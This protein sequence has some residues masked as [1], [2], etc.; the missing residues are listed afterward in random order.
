MAMSDAQKMAFVH[1]MTH[2]ALSHVQ[3]FDAGGVAETEDAVKPQIYNPFDPS[4]SGSVPIGS[5]LT[6]EPGKSQILSPTSANSTTQPGLVT[7]TDNTTAG[8]LFGKTADPSGGFGHAAAGAINNVGGIFQG[9][10]SAFT[11]QNNY[12]AGTAPTTQLNYE[13]PAAQGVS[14]LQA[15]YGQ[16]NALLNNQQVLENQLAAQAAGAGPNPAQAAL[17]QN[18]GR[19]IKQAAALAASTRGAGANAGMVAENAARQGAETQQNAIG[20]A[21]TL[22]AQQRLDAQKAQQEQQQ[23]ELANIQGEQGIQGSLYGASA[24][25]NNAQNNTNVSNYG[26][27]QGINAQAAQNNAN[28]V[29]KTTSGFVSGAGSALAALFAQGGEV[30][31]PSH[32]KKIH[33][34]YYARGGE[35]NFGVWNPGSPS[36]NVPRLPEGVGVDIPNPSSM[37]KGMKGGS[38]SSSSTSG[39]LP[40]ASGDYDPLGGVTTTG[41]ENADPLAGITST[42]FSSAP[43]YSKGGKVGDRLKSGGKVP[44]KPK[45]SHDAYKNDTVSAKLSPGEVVIDLNTLKDKGKLGQMARFVAQNIERKKAGRA[46]V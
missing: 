24:N 35:V 3:H 16:S 17:N 44:G 22:E 8:G 41:S 36:V 38:S 30:E 11:N 5:N 12:Q 45:V 46:L 26:M 1:K 39:G 13:V 29:N 21:A 15:G 9:L 40:A 14:N 23:A 28:A 31:L 7:T 6:A 37:M 43:D 27:A 4:P 34:I 2:L 18:T 42:G 25:A 33:S 19:N 10:G 20:Q 32:L